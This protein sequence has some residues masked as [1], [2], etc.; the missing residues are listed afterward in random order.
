M[1]YLLRVKGKRI[2]IP[3]PENLKNNE[4]AEVTIKRV[5]VDEAMQKRIGKKAI[6][7]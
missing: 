5:F 7:I 3:T 4:I 2:C 6:A 1:A